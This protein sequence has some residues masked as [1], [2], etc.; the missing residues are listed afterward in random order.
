MR[1]DDRGDWIR[2]QLLS[3][4]VSNQSTLW[5]VSFWSVL[6]VQLNSQLVAAEG[7]GR[8]MP[9][10]RSD[11]GSNRQTPSWFAAVALAA[12]GLGHPNTYGC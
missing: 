6:R 8:P 5:S 11:D 7:E 2:T 9:G 1:G 10:H 4:S 3:P 12:E